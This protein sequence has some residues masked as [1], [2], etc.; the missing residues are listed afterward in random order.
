M[1]DSGPDG[2]LARGAE[3]CIEHKRADRSPQ[4][5]DRG[6]PGNLCVR[7]H[8]RNQVGRDR[9]AGKNVSAQPAP[10]IAAQYPDPGQIAVGAARRLSP[11]GLISRQ[12]SSRL[13]RLEATAPPPTPPPEIAMLT[14]SMNPKS[15]PTGDVWFSR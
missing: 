4:S 6:K 9:H 12:R 10:L 1:L 2:E 11:G 3:D 13:L 7:H 8:L 5:G 15:Y 14:P